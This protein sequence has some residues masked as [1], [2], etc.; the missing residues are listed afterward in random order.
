MEDGIH[1]NALMNMNNDGVQL[2]LGLFILI[3]FVYLVSFY[4]IHVMEVAGFLPIPDFRMNER[5]GYIS[6]LKT[7]FSFS[8]TTH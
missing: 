6:C 5:K 1:L 7:I 2:I 4:I 3:P 8:H